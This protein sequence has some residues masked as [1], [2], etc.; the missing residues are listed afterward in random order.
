VNCFDA[1]TL[2]RR[3]VELT[4]RATVLAAGRP[5]PGHLHLAVRAGRLAVVFHRRSLRA[6]VADLS[7]SWKQGADIP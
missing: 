3:A 7:D 2:S 1:L 5:S 4:C 6:V